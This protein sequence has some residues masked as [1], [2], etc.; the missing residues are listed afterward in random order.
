[1]AKEQS[2][3]SKGRAPGT[4]VVA[5]AY[6]PGPWKVVREDA[7]R[8]GWTADNDDV[9]LYSDLAIR[10][11]NGVVALV[12]NDDCEHSDETLEANARLIAAAPELLKHSR[13]AYHALQSY[14]FGNSSHEL[15]EE[16]CLSLDTLISQVEGRS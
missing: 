4:R 16:I 5:D 13:A 10:G 6:I 1:M 2:A 3:S 9:E 14:R 8:D 7:L 11:P 15:A 12:V